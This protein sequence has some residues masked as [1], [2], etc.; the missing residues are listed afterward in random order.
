HDDWYLPSRDELLGLLDDC[1]KISYPDG[2]S[3]PD[4]ECKKCSESQVCNELF[5]QEKEI[6]RYWSS[7][8]EYDLSW[9]VRLYEGFSSS[10]NCY[11]G[12]SV[13]CVR[14]AQ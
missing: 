11:F 9:E 6:Y 5:G 2:G 1:E 4:Y 8:Y 13:R 12:N 10:S 14:K 7:T 3:I